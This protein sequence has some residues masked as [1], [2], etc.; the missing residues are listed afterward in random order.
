MRASLP[1]VLHAIGGRSL[2]A[3]VLQTAVAAGGAEIAVV[4]GPDHMAVAGEVGR[5][6]AKA[7]VLN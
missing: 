6:A 2:I 4:I 7:D 1:K 5:I 3:H